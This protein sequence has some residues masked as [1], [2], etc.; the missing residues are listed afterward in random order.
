MSLNQDRRESQRRPIGDQNRHLNV[1]C[2]GLTF[3]GR[4]H[5]ADYPKPL[6]R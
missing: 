2:G 1:P 6:Q 3:V 4:P 5:V